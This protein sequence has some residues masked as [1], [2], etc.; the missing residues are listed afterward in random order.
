MNKP[1]NPSEDNGVSQ[2]EQEDWVT[3]C[4]LEDIATNRGHFVEY[5]NRGLAV[6]RSDDDVIY[7]MDNVCPHAGGSLADGPIH[8]GCVICP[9]HGWAFG[10]EDGKCPDNPQITVKTFTARIMDGQV[11]IRHPM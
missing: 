8:D 5:K 11:Q 7:V 2:P 9:W 6:I 10:I 1:A 3:L 4:A